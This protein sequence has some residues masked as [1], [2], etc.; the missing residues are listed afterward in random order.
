MLK[1]EI[2]I[3]ERDDGAFDVETSEWRQGE[4]SLNEERLASAITGTID[5]MNDSVDES[6]KERLQREMEDELAAVEIEQ[7][8]TDPPETEER[9]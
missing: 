7:P 1:L 9:E 3:T 4:V 5:A 8:F 6:D 2:T